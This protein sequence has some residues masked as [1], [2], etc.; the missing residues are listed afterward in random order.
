MRESNFGIEKTFWNLGLFD[1]LISIL[2]DTLTDHG[3]SRG[4][5]TAFGGIR[6]KYGG[7]L[8]TER[9]FVTFLMFFQS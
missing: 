2:V 4:K 7:V 3:V 5:T 9:R 1:D 8:S 6:C